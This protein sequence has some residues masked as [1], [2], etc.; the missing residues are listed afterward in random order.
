[1]ISIKAFEC[2]SLGALLKK[3]FLI[4]KQTHKRGSE[5]ICSLYGRQ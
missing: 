3:A 4:D 5:L 1:M 2:G